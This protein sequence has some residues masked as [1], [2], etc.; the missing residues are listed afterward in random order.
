MKNN[1]SKEIYEEFGSLLKEI[2][3]C[4]SFKTAYSKL[5]KFIEE[6]VKSDNKSYGTYLS[7]RTENYLNFTKY[8]NHV[9]SV[10]RSANTVDRISD[11]IK[12]ARRNY[13][14]YFHNKRELTAKLKMIFDSMAKHK[15]RI[16]RYQNLSRILGST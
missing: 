5:A 1:L 14:G 8:P 11:A 10:I 6:K 16:Y 9:R 15:W 4:S 3:L 2:Y 12:I 7:E 13:E